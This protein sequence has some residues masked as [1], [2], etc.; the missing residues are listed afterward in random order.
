M[1][2]S[3]RPSAAM[4]STAIT[5]DHTPPPGAGG[6]TSARSSCSAS[7]NKHLERMGSHEVQQHGQI[8][9]LAPWQPL[10]LALGGVEV[11]AP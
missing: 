1:S 3:R 7:A 8:D 6:D 9:V 5:T 10:V 2:R 4:A 11:P